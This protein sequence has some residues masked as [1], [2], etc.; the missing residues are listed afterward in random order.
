MYA[1]TWPEPDWKN[2]RLSHCSVGELLLESPMTLATHEEP[3]R[4]TKQPFIVYVA[5]GASKQGRLTSREPVG[6]GLKI[7][8]LCKLP[9]WQ[10]VHALIGVCFALQ[11]PTPAIGASPFSTP[12]L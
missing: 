1:M 7:V 4:F 6:S 8:I 11:C 5:L 9:A 2:L 10:S 12:N 3:R